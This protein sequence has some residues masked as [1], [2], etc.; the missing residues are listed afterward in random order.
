MG[1]QG[2]PR[3]GHAEQPAVGV[4][5]ELRYAAESICLLGQPVQGVVLILGNLPERVNHGLDPACAVREQL[6][7][8]AHRI[9]HACKV[10][11]RVR[12]FPGISQ[13][14]SGRDYAPTRVVCVRR[15]LPKRVRGTQKIALIVVPEIIGM[16]QWVGDARDL[17]EDRIVAKGCRYGIRG[18]CK[19]R[20]TGNISQSV[21]GIGRL[22]VQRICHA[23]KE[24]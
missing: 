23:Q 4:I 3:I 2:I 19:C 15:S 21:V 13:G 14:I 18:T 5:P 20:D 12:E 24:P 8:V 17:A 1:I 6:G 22:A 16:L 10:S 11:P 7:V 9:R